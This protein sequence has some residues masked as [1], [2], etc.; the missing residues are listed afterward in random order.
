MKRLFL[1]IIVISS[2]LASCGE[3]TVSYREVPQEKVNENVKIFIQSVQG[4]QDQERNGIYKYYDKENIQYLYVTQDF[5]TDGKG[6]GGLDI[7][8]D[9]D[10]MHL[11]LKESEEPTEDTYRL[12]RI[13]SNREFTY[14]KIYKNGEETYFGTIGVRGD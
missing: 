12:Y 14:S 13:E 2:L 7:E 8:T 6:F 9:A 5:L 3:N 1:L 4:I 10:S 11:Y